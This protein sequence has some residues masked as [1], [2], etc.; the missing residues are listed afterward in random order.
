MWCRRCGAEYVAGVLRCNDCDSVL[1]ER[2][3]DWADDPDALR[4][5]DAA[6]RE[7]SIRARFRRRKR[8]SVHDAWRLSGFLHPG[9]RSHYRSIGGLIVRALRTA[10]YVRV[11]APENRMRKGERLAKGPWRD[12][13]PWPL[14]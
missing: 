7:L 12:P 6:H 11:G 9:R 14:P 3:P 2:E 5:I 1:V 4:K 10:W 8:L 13:P